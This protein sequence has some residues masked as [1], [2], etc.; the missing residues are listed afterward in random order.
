MSITLIVFIAGILV[1]SIS[2]WLL[3]RSFT[4]KQVAELSSRLELQANTIQQLGKEKNEVTKEKDTL[5]VRATKAE[6]Q[7]EGL[8][9]FYDDKIATQKL[10]LENMKDK[11]Q[12]EFRNLAQSILEEK[13]EKFTK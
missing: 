6:E 3:H 4:G 11:M 2:A 8:Q 5:L 7:K 12:H 9:K 1:T 13:S 10:D